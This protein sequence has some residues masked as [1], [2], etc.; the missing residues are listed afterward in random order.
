MTPG[1]QLHFAYLTLLGA[2]CPK[3]PSGRER[4]AGGLGI[5]CF[6][7]LFV[8]SNFCLHVRLCNMNVCVHARV[9][10]CVPMFVYMEASAGV[11]F[12]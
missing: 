12:N 6:C 1:G 4:V 7:L 9:C 8:F 3:L 2:Q 10:V 11:F 5:F